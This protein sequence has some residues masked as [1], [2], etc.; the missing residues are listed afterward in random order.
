[1]VRQPV[2][3]SNLSSVGYDS[4][5]KVLEVEF[6]NGSVY[7]YFE[8]PESKYAELIEA[9]SVG[10]YFNTHIKNVFQYTQVK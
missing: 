4:Q 1:M 5:K 9:S 10:S 2:S 7:Q 8:V 3:S 6:K